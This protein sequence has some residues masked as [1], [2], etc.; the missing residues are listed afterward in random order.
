MKKNQT[1]RGVIILALG[2]AYWGRWAYNLAMSLKYTCPEIKIT[3]LYAGN[4]LTHIVDRSLFD[5]V[6]KVPSK[7]YTTNGRVQYLKA[8]T[9]LYKLSPYDETIYLDADMVWLPKRSVM[10]LFNELNV[11]FTMANRSWMALES[12]NLTDTF[13]VWASPKYI[14]DVF[15]FKE[16]RFYNLSSEM[17]YFKKTKEVSKLFSDAFKLFDAEINITIFNGGMPDELPFTISMIKNNIYPHKDN[18]KPFYWES[19][20]HLRLQGGDLNNGFYAYSMGGHISH[21]M[22]KKTYDNLVQFYCNQFNQI[23]PF[24]WKDKRGW[25]PARQNL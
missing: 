20:E 12:E 18:Y 22:M 8:K 23:S 19:A 25:M 4:G 11:D 6:I 21:P 16:G 14:K 9:A 13:G 7:Y 15:K 3:L 1:N 24:F 5:K 17:I 10:T 2:H